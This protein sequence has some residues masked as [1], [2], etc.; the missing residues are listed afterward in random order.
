MLK[1][2]PHPSP[3]SNHLSLNALVVVRVVLNT[4]V[5]LLAL[6]RT[7]VVLAAA[8]VVVLDKANV[9]SSDGASWG[10]TAGDLVRWACLGVPLVGV[11]RGGSDD[12][13][14]GGS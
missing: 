14:T 7:V 1:L 9:T 10:S 11:G 5:R 13:S 4:L 3:L 2:N 12:G 6:S 8:L